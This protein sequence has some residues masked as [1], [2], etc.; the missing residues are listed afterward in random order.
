MQ[1]NTPSQNADVISRMSLWN[2]FA[3]PLFSWPS[4]LGLLF[5]SENEI[6]T[7]TEVIWKQQYDVIAAADDFLGVHALALFF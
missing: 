6:W 3:S 1:D 2:A 7:T 5:A 4:I